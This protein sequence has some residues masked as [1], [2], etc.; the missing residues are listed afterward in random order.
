MMQLA[1]AQYGNSNSTVT[2][3]Q[4]EEC[5]NLGIKPD[6]C[7]ENAILEHRCLGGVGAPCGG[8]YRPSELD[9]VVLSILVGSGLALVTGTLCVR[10][11]RKVRKKD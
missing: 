3:E 7:T 1:S 10:K 5:K 11:V 4:L 8:S 6:K 2:T 9:P